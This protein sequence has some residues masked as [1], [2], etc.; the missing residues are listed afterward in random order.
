ML[1][2]Y[3]KAISN[4]PEVSVYSHYYMALGEQVDWKSL[5]TA[6]AKLKGLPTKQVSFEEAGFLN[7]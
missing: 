6:F 5:A 7:A 1:L 3:S 2:V 4:K